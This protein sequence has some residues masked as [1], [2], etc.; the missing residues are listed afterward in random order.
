MLVA[1]D[2]WKTAFPGAAVGALVMRGVRNPEQSAAL[3]DRKRQLER[4]LRERAGDDVAGDPVVRAYGDYYRSHGK[5][6]H[7]KAQWESVAVKGRPI[8]SRAALVEAMFMAELED[9]VLTAGHDLA[10]VALPVA[11]AVTADD[12]RYVALNGKERALDAGD[13]MMADREG[14]ISSVL[15]GPDRRTAIT[16]DTGA[17]LFAVYAP[18]GVGEPAV[19][20]HLEQIRANVLLIAP[21]AAT[22]QLETLPAG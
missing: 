15:H 21:D 6:Y 1:T 5:S 18:A 14:I 2:A 20:Q 3:E 10:A 12:D 16:P 4:E 8:P 17:V 11:V 22:E 13:M 19:R 9:L 7:V